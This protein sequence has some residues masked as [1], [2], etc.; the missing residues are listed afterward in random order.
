LSDP[1]QRRP[2]PSA[3]DSLTAG[4]R[5]GAGAPCLSD[6]CLPGKLVLID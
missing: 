2:A 1:P 4:L 5:R 6:R 3:R